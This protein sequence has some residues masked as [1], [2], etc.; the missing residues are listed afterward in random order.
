[1]IEVYNV[2]IDEK[3]LIG[4]GPLYSKRPADPTLSM[5]YNE[6]QFYFEVYTSKY[7]FVIT[8]DWL[9]FKE[10]HVESSKL[11]QS[12]IVEAHKTLRACL[13][14][15]CFNPLLIFKEHIDGL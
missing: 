6:R 4:V 12:A 8:T 10:P 14:D 5:L 2:L 3:Q 9:S 7:H 1:M 15:G 11:A 13:I